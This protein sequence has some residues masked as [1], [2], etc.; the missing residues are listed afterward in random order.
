MDEKLSMEELVLNE[1]EKPVEVKK[2][3]PVKEEGPDPRITPIEEIPSM[4][5]FKEEINHSFKKLKS[6]D[7]VNGTVIGVSE[8]EV[9][10]DLG[11]Y[12]E[13]IIKLEELS[14]DP[15]FS[16]KA[17]ILVG[18]KV[19]ATVLREDKVGNI[20]LSLK[21]A[22]DILA[23]E[24]LSKMKE[25]RTLTTI[26]VAEAVKGG[27]TTFLKGVRA[28][29]PASQLDLNYVEDPS[30]FVG[31]E[32]T[33]IVTEVNEENKKL[34]LSA[35]EPA[36]EKA[37]AD[38]TSRIGKLQEGLVTE[39]T[40]EKLMPFGAFVNIGEDLSGLVHISQIC[41]KHIRHPKEVLAEGDKVT[42]K[43]I[44]VKDG[45]ISLSIKAVE[46]KEE[47]LEDVVDDAPT[48]YSDGGSVSTGLGA[49]LAK[50]N[51]K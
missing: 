22:D 2:P 27:A 4:D 48:E 51:I 7:I 30:T 11:S 18:D 43:V 13:G 23:W 35:K 3:E 49:L 26:K 17:D 39:G 16:I 44:G 37:A 38:R 46:E 10:V 19:T 14:N 15:R 45:K 28:F 5:E 6:G 9:T 25:E 1:T 41:G 36:R 34:I 24:E 20:L 31:K 12:A 21:Q 42:V 8:T 50:L 47:V 29:I 40:V 33:V 32:L